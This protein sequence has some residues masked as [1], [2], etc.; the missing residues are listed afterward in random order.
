[1]PQFCNGDGSDPIIVENFQNHIQSSL[2]NS[3]PTIT[4]YFGITEQSKKGQSHFH[5]IV[6]IRNFIDYNYVLKN[7]IKSTLID[8]L[9]NYFD[10]EGFL[11]IK[12]DSLLYFKD[13]K[14][15]IM[16]MHKDI[17]G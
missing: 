9:E 7:N 1:L 8:C 5:S 16:Y 6:A 3:Y 4:F 2:S 11:D 17:G 12:V 14:N 10:H 15:W 13:V